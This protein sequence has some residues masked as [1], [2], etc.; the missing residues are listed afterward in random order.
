MIGYIASF[1]IGM[2]AGVFIMALCVITK[3]NDYHRNGELFNEKRDS[4]DSK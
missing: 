4:K 1:V 2:V 3:K